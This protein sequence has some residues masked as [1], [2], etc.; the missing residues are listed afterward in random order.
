LTV[1]YDVILIKF[2]TVDLLSVTDERG[3]WGSLRTNYR[4]AE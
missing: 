3:D 4:V 2:A 1:G